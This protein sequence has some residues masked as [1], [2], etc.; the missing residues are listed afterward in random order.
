MKS[1]IKQNT[2]QNEISKKNNLKPFYFIQQSKRVFTQK[3]IMIILH[4]IK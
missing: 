1:I 3:H 4:L 2:T